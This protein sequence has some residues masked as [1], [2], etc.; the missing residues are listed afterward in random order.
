MQNFIT[1]SL[2]RRHKDGR[3]ELRNMRYITMEREYGSG[4]TKIAAELAK[5]CQIPCFGQEILEMASEKLNMPVNAI[6]EYEEKASN[7]L[8]Y[9]I[10]MLSQIQNG[11]EGMLSPEAKVFVEE[12]NV[13]RAL[14]KQGS[15]IFLGHCA[16]E[17]L[18]DYQSVIS[19]YIYGDPDDKHERIKKD[20][21]IDDS[22][23][24]LM[25]KKNNKRR[26]NYFAV[27]TQKKWDDFRN[28][29]IVL[30]S[31]RLGIEGCVRILESQLR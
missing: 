2:S 15:A 16:T 18:K 9:S 29:D 11:S 6:R 4:G 31:S 10:Y 23:V 22:Q 19:V 26:A 27:N 30:N 17:A 28:Y 1:V 25:E 12:Q 24:T 8:L 13:I 3:K 14:A 20:Y 21:G 7:S 5:K